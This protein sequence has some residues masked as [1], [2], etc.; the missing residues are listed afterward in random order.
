MMYTS[1][2]ALRITEAHQHE[3]FEAWRQFKICYNPSGCR[4]GLDQA[5][6]IMSRKPCKHL[7]EVPAAIDV[8]ERDLIY[9]DSM[10][11]RDWP[12]EL[13]ILLLMQFL[14]WPESYPEAA[15]RSTG[16]LQQ[17]MARRAS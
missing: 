6:R 7:S 16:I 11:G 15:R 17:G 10:S 8:M 1:D 14:N 9:Y 13:K 4:I 12:E 3:G 2:G 5:L